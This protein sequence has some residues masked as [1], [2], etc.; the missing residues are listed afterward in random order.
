MTAYLL[1]SLYDTTGMAQFRVMA[2]GNFEIT[3]TYRYE[4]RFELGVSQYDDIKT[5]MLL[6]EIPESVKG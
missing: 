3:L 5:V 4:T 1:T 2:E 6:T